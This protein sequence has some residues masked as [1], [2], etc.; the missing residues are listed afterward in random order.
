MTLVSD[1]GAAAAIGRDASV[2]LSA[3]NGR[4]IVDIAERH[5]NGSGL[6]TLILHPAL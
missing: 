6:R 5:R 1:T 2:V 3:L 4:E